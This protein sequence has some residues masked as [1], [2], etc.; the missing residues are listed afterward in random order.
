MANT[1]RQGCHQLQSSYSKEKRWI[2]TYGLFSLAFLFVFAATNFIAN[3]LD[4]FRIT[5]TTILK[6][7]IIFNRQQ[8]QF[9]LNCTNEKLA[10]TCPSYYPTKFQFYDNSSTTSCPE[11]FRWIHE[12]LKP[13]ESTGITRDMIERGKNISHFRLVIVN[14]KAYIEKFAKSYQTR[15][16]FTIWGILQLLRLYPGKVPDLELMF[17]CGDKTVVFKKDFQ[18]PQMSP[19]PVFHY[20]GEENSYDI[21]WLQE[22]ASNFEN[23]KLE[24]QCTFRYKI[25]AE[26]ATWSVSEKYIIACDSMTMF[27]EP[28]YYDFF[29]RNMLP[30]RHYWPISTKNMCEEIKYAVDWGNAH[31]D[32]AQAIGDGGTN[33]I[34]ENLKMKFVYDYM[35]HLL[36]NY[37]KLLKF[38]PTIPIGAVE[39]CSE[40]M[41]CSL[42]G[43]RK[44]FMVES[45][46]ISPSDT[47]PCIM[48]PPYTPE[49]LKE[50]LQEKE[51]LIKQVKTRSRITRTTIFKT[52]IIF[53]KQQPQFPLNCTDGN[54]AKTCSSYYPTTFDLD[55]DSSTTSC[56]NYF[57]WIHEDLKPWKSKGITRDMVERGKN[58]S[59]FRLVIVN[60][61]AYVEKYDKVYQTRDVFTIWGILQLLR[62]YP[63]KIPDLD[64]MFQCGDK[65][66]V[67]KKD[68]QGPQ[69]MSPPPVFHYCGDENAHDIINIGPWETTLHKILEGN[70]MIKWKDRTPY[71]FWKGNLAMADIRRELGKCNPTKE[72]DWNARIHNI[73]WNK[74]EANNFE[75]SKLENQCNFRYKI[76]VE[77]AA[78]SVS[79]KYIIGCDSM[80]LFIEPTYYEFFT[81]S[82]VPLQHY[83]PISPKNMCEDIKYAVD[84]GN[85]HLDNAQVIGNGG[86]NFIVENLKTKFVYDYMFYLLNEYAKLLKFKPT[87]PTGA[88]EICSE[89]MACSVHGLEKRFMV[90][91]MVTSPS[92]T[93][94]CTMPPPYTPETLKEF[95]QEKENIIK[96]VKTKEVN[97]KI[98]TV[99]NMKINFTRERRSDNM[100][101]HILFSSHF[102][103]KKIIVYSI[104]GTG[105]G[106]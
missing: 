54:L 26:G 50:F 37:S 25:Y 3:W 11:Y 36:N 31:L 55:D 67:L 13:W 76:Y 74:E 68:F 78:W 28:K 59:H 100:A 1:K 96:Q 101:F 70:K 38:K 12:D 10:T 30:L 105:I 88:V 61:K 106:Y 83:W 66:V 90:E 60:G 22:R 95:L 39:I 51:N 53:N 29:T 94:P 69:A 56:P 45:M 71:A 99:K 8:P 77:G 87:I 35:F 20:C 84:W 49:T 98:F 52:I 7:N 14:G 64:L 40:S 4:L 57:K 44:H 85:A 97:T 103:A 17:H 19:P 63:G 33:Y 92:D 48:P 58:V 82:M 5:S 62:L 23:S 41:A 80:T 21:Q 27:I 65:P 75:S 15:D 42:H 86:T 93:P 46:V 91:S 104:C 43:Q 6:T 18:G 2:S 9:P 89:S 73:Q 72:H 79:E 24:N 34:L 102:Q 81:R 47:P 32:H 16:V